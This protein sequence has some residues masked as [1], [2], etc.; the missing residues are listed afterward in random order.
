MKWAWEK[1]ETDK[2]D[3]NEWFGKV[4]KNDFFG[5]L[6]QAAENTVL[7]LFGHE[8]DQQREER[9]ENQRYWA[10]YTK[11]TGLEPKYPNM[12]G[13]HPGV[14]AYSNLG[15]ITGIAKKLYGGMI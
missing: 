3:L 11:N 7:P 14:E 4:S 13:K 5:K 15:P 6:Y 9:T 2:I 10:D 1:E 8:T 12:A